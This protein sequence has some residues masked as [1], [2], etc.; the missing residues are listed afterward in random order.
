MPNLAI[1]G[2]PKLRE[3]DFTPW[4]QYTEE[5]QKGLITT[6]ESGKWGYGGEQ[7]Q[8]FCEEFAAY[9]KANM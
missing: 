9:T 2:G 3:K 6:Y 8:K 7:N 5:D 1:N 4:T